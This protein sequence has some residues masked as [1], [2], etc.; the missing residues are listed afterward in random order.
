[1][2]AHEL[3]QALGKLSRAETPRPPLFPAE[4][5]H[6]TRAISRPRTREVTSRYK[7]PT[8]VASSGARRSPSPDVRRTE[9][10]D[11]SV[12]KRAISAERKRPTAPSGPLPSTPSQDTNVESVLASRKVSGN[13]LAEFLWPSTM[14]S[15]HVSFQSDT[16]SVPVSKREEPANHVSSDRTLR[17]S[18]NVARKH[19]ETPP[20]SRKSTPERKRSPLKGKNFAEQ[21][22]N[23]RPT[24]YAH[25]RLV[26]QHRWPSRVGGKA[27]SNSL[28]R[29]IDFTEKGSSISSSPQ[30]GKGRRLSLDGMTK[31]PQRS[32]TEL[33]GLINSD[34]GGRKGKFNRSIDDYALIVDRRTSSRLFEKTKIVDPVIRSQSLPTPGSCHASV[35]ASS[36]SRGV[37]PSRVKSGSSTPPSKGTSPARSR[38]SSPTRQS[39]QTSVLSF[40]ADIKK[41][42]KAANHIEDVHQ[43]RLLY[44]RQLQWRFANAQADVSLHSQKEKAERT[45]YTTW[46]TTLNLWHSFIDK[47]TELHQMRLK[48]KLYTIL[49]E[50]LAYLDKWESIEMDHTDSL[51]KATKDL[52]ACTLRLPITGGARG[53]AQSVKAAVSSAVDILEAMGNSVCCSLPKVEDMNNMVSEVADVAAQEQVMLY[54]CEALLGSILAM[55]AEESSLR[56]HLIQLKEAWKSARLVL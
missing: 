12:P 29:S 50:Q 6:G 45:L 24:E 38:T 3:Q 4:K 9:S 52:Q 56:S 19:N 41:G 14:R 8:P 46:R 39:N 25:S 30:P 54:E 17:P 2:D 36:A 1:M 37:S 10:S 53:D 13:R 23:S 40:I 11:I 22:E 5:N 20:G 33:L 32:T 7:S 18:I 26:E 27:S 43:L 48:S 15:L 42:K 31:P 21:S 55:Q 35:S 28:S 47:Q 44:N 51:I 16:S 49:K 34:E